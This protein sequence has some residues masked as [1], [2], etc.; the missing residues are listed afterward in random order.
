MAKVSVTVK[1]AAGVLAG[2]DGSGDKGLLLNW[3]N[4]P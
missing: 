2:T 1:G 4:S 3:G